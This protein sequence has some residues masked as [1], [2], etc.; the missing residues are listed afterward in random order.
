MRL[1]GPIFKKCDNAQDWIKALK[2]EK[3]SAAYCPVKNDVPDETII[4]YVKAAKEAGIIIAEVGAWSNPLSPDKK[5][6]RDAAD[7]C[8][9][10]LELAEKIG[11]KCCVNISGSRSAQW[12]GPSGNNL[13]EETF[14]LIV[15]VVRDIIRSVK[16]K[17]AFYTL[18]TMPWMYPD[19][20]DSYLELIKAIDC[21]Q[22]GV[23]FDPVNLI[24]SPQR[25]YNNAVIIKDFCKKLGRFIKSCHAKDI[26]LSGK[27]TTHL[28]EVRPGTGGIDYKTYLK[29]V[30]KLGKD[31]PVM[32]EHLSSK[33]EY[34]K[35]AAYIRSVEKE[36]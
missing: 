18:E 7:F 5:T 23:H 11:A 6:R 3:Y 12:D 31:I 4:D 19:S 30:N 2:E 20:A 1:G 27:L 22:F 35:A 32:L 28:D 33:S 14:D 8:K 16:P 21:K 25:F 24:C 10:Q 9:K 13:T 17:K 36:L 34:K 29:E 15:C 26:S